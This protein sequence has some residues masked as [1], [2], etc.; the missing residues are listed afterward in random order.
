VLHEV[1]GAFLRGSEPQALFERLLSLLVEVTGCQAAVVGECVRSPSSP[2]P[3]V[4][5]RTPASEALGE[6]L[7]RQLT[8]GGAPDAGPAAFHLLPVEVE[9]ERLG[10]VGLEG[11]APVEEALRPWLETCGNL[12]W[13]LREREARR[14]HEALQR[15]RALVADHTHNAVILT[16]ARGRVEWVNASF[17]RLSGYTLEE[18]RGR[19]PDEVLKGDEVANAP[20]LETVR[21][22]LRRG[23]GFIVEL[24]NYNRRG[25]RYW[26]LNETQPLFDEQGRLTH[27]MTLETDITHR[28]QME[29]ALALSAERLELALEGV[30]DGVSD[31]NRDTG[32]MFLSRRGLE[33][34]GYAGGELKLTFEDWSNLVH[35]ED[36]PEAS[37]RMREHQEGRRSFFEHEQRLRHK[38][39]HWVWVLSR[40]KMVKWDEQGRPVRMVG[41]FA[42]ITERKREAAHQRAL[43]EALPD[44]LFRVSSDGTV[45]DYKANNPQELA[46]P[47]EALI[48][49]NFLQ[50]P[51][52][53]GS[54]LVEALQRAIR[55]DTL[56]V[57]EYVLEVP[58]GWQYYE[59]RLVRSGP[60]EGVCIVR[61]ITERKR[62]EER[63]RQQ[64]EELRHHRDHLE[65]LVEERTRE[66]RQATRELEAH[67]AQ[68]VQSEK[69]A[70]LGQMAAGVAHEIN[71]PVSY[72]LSNLGTLDQYVTALSQVLR[73]QKDLLD[74]QGLALPVGVAELLGRLRTLWVQQEVD[75]ILEDMPELVRESHEGTRH[76]KEIAQGLRSFAREDSGE[77]AL[78]DVNTELES[79]LKIVWN[80]LKYKCEVKRDF[81]EL[82]R[83]SFHATQLTQVFANLLVNAAQA[84]EKRGEIHIATRQ[85][86]GEVVVRISDTGHG[87]S[88][89]TLSKLFQPFFT[90]KPRGKGTGLG[91][92]ISYGI[93][94]RHKG[95]IDV[96][97]EPG[98]GSTF[99]VRLP[100]AQGGV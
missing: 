14:Q 67:H 39:G 85:E 76:I 26:V 90:T 86:G 48:G 78:V 93:I 71:N 89:E 19:R 17:T 96:Q 4:W 38:Q 41:T 35:P 30:A 6:W 61:N 92:S 33:I 88:P 56:Q 18:L 53:V 80:E 44:L 100:V 20:M 21:Q 42:D 2:S 97:S 72:V 9:G 46:I 3:R 27:F 98:K 15:L 82:P 50:L 32:E 16:D 69:L 13:A 54:Q 7:A 36:R 1:Q 99:I 87:M 65:E 62:T 8:P 74:L 25:E 79:T 23:E 29:Q 63:L 81:S 52:P 40:A 51:A 11:G 84:I 73:L 5:A 95:R 12:L 66:L 28:R 70:S 31:W 64:E 49:S 45:L 83:V 59:A 57:I 91:L 37:R 10:G 55:Q 43:L 58:R 47:A 34:L 75:Y 94:T 22:S 77:A 60:E 68:L 24:C